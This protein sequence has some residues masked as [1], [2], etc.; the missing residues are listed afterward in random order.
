M[1]HIPYKGGPPALQAVLSG[2]VALDF[3]GAAAAM[4]FMHSGHI[5]CLAVTTKTRSSAFPNLPTLSEAGITG[6]EHSLWN[7]IFAPSGTARGRVSL[8]CTRTRSADYFSAG[9]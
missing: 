4:P 7:G 3:P 9:K 2:E 5:R 6:Y 8:R 1:R